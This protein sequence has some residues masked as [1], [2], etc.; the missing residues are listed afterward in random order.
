M[1]E[2]DE[3]DEAGII[4]ESDSPWA[5][6]VVVAKKKNGKLRIRVD[7]WKLNQVTQADDT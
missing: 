6:P 1:K 5:A 2:L 7:Y 4:N 3:M